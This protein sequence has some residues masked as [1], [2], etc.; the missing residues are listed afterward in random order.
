MIQHL[1]I[2]IDWLFVCSF[3]NGNDHCTR[4]SFDKYY[5]PIVEIKVFNLLLDNKPFFD[6]PVKI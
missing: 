3:K 4:D 5:I 1:E 2:L 6:Q